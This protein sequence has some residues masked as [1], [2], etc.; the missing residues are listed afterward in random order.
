MSDVFH[1]L[2]RIRKVEEQIARVETVRREEVRDDRQAEV[3]QLDAHMDQSREL[4]QHGAATLHHHHAFALHQ[5]MRR[6]GAEADL[7]AA[8]IAV[9]DAR[10]T[11]RKTAIDARTVELLAEAFAE[12]V[13]T[14][15]RATEQRALDEVGSQRWLRKAG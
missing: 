15:A 1:R 11:L 12:R 9:E 14:N 4:F 2:H 10:A 3:I 6:R 7:A 13:A 8:N 5:E